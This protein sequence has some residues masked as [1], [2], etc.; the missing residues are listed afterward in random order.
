M[1]GTSG[2]YIFDL[3]LHSKSRVRSGF[4]PIFRVFAILLNLFSMR[5]MLDGSFLFA[6]TADNFKSSFGTD[7]AVSSGPAFRQVGKYPYKR[8]LRPANIWSQFLIFNESAFLRNGA[9]SGVV[10]DFIRANQLF[11]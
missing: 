1:D 11:C 7:R 2:D 10:G 5:D 6:E 3:T 8:E 9:P 4:R